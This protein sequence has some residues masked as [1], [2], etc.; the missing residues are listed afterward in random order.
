[1]FQWL[2][3][4]CMY[5]IVGNFYKGLLKLRLLADLHNQTLVAQC[6]LGVVV[7]SL[8]VIISRNDDPF[9]TGR[10]N[11][12]TC[13][14]TVENVADPPTVKWL[15]PNKNPLTNNDDITVTDTVALNCSTY[16]TVL[17][18]TTLHTS[19]GGQYSCQATL[20]AVNNTAAVNIT[21]QSKSLQ[22]VLFW[23]H[24]VSMFPVLCSSSSECD[25]Y[26]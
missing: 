22:V 3:A 11:N 4:T 10:S 18:F 21:V 23:S 20:G 26:N 12:L 1:M 7:P 6:C 15:D 2:V 25:Y 5:H 17:H 9:I 8:D 16:T 14:V 13:T 24:F 19:H